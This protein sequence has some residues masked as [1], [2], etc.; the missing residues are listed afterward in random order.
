MDNIIFYFTGTG[1]SLKIAKIISNKI[2]KCEIVPT[3]SNTGIVINKKYESIGFIYPIY[4]WGIPKN[5]KAFI[6]S[7]VINNNEDT[8]FYAIATYGG[9]AGNGLKLLN[10]MLFDKN[11]KLKYG[12][13]LK[14]F[15]N[16]IIN[17][18]MPGKFKKL[19]EKSEKKLM[20]IVDS[21]KN[22]QT[23]TI[24]KMSKRINQFYEK[25]INSLHDEDKNYTV[26]SSCIGCG[27]CKEV[28]PVN[29]IEIKENRP[30]FKHTCEQCMACIQYCP[31]KAINYKNKTQ[32][33]MR[34]THPEINYKE[35]SE[36]NKA[37]YKE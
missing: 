6:S 22:K 12:K 23:N 24:G 27:I 30:E 3:G 2:N 26:H 17:F 33:K 10:K 32:G 14:V 18:T 37:K 8:Y 7:M 1:N 20:P 34:Y 9:F 16:Y 11:I 13:T 36:C 35:L 25:S 29:N 28:C 31:Q 19:L 21:I 4:F 15:S 5:V